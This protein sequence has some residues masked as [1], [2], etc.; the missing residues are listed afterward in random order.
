[1]RRHRRTHDAVN[2]YFC[3]NPACVSN[4]KTNHKK[5]TKGRISARRS[6]QAASA[7]EN[8]N[9]ERYV[10]D[11]AGMG[12]RKRTWSKVFHKAT[13]EDK[14]DDFSFPQSNSM[15][16]VQPCMLV[17]VAASAGSVVDDFLCHDYLI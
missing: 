7:E 11:E 8:Q 14:C 3:P 17:L 5:K 15:L 9:C 4:W 2:T 12:C 10:C 13:Q 16:S 1:M 6:A